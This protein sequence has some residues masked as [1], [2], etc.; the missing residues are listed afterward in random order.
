MIHV[1]PTHQDVEIVTGFTCDRCKKLIHADEY[2]FHEAHHINFV[3]GYA[4]V[5]GDG[6]KVACDL[7]QECLHDLIKEFCRI[8][9]G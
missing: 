7:C 1:Q 4:S 5:F 9:E 8:S 3:G 6:S 2:A